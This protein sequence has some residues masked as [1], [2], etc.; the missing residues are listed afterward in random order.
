MLQV[1]GFQTCALPISRSPFLKVDYLEK[2]HELLI[3]YCTTD[4]DQESSFIQDTFTVVKGGTTE[5]TGGLLSIRD[6]ETYRRW[7]ETLK[8]N[9]T[10][11]DYEVYKS[12]ALSPTHT[13][14][15]E[16]TEIDPMNIIE[17]L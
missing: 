17:V 11:I 7:G 9:P 10:L 5:T 14:C 13:K 8:Y 6:P 1:T 2:E 15:T 12:I 3:S 4:R 16:A